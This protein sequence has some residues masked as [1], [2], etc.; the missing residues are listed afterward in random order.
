MKIFSTDITGGPGFPWPNGGPHGFT[1]GDYDTVRWGTSYAAPSTA[2][3]SALLLSLD[4]NLTWD[5]VRAIINKTADKVGAYTY[6]SPGPLPNL[7]STWNEEMGYGKVNA[8]NA[9]RYVVLTSVNQHTNYVS[10]NFH[11]SQNYP[12]PFNPVTVINFELPQAILN[13]EFGRGSL[14]VRLIIYDITGRE[15][16]LLVNKE[17]RAGKHEVKWNAANYPS[18]VYFYELIAGEFRETKKMLLIR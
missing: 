17:L 16:A 2:G 14:K 3:V 5:S 15:V 8:Y 12:N 13:D 10:D 11:L 7:G 9:L 4:S 18:G 1:D 6:T